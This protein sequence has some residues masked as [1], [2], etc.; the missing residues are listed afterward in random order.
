MAIVSDQAD[1]QQ[2]RPLHT[3][4]LAVDEDHV[5]V[6]DLNVDELAGRELQPM[7]DVR[8]LFFERQVVPDGSQVLRESRT[9]S[10]DECALPPP[11]QTAATCNWFVSK[12]P[13]AVPPLW[14]R[15]SAAVGGAYA[16]THSEQVGVR[17]TLTGE[18]DITE[19]GTALHLCIA[20]AGVLGKADLPEVERILTNWK[21][22]HAVDKASVLAPLTAFQDW[23]QQRW[24]G[25]VIHV[26][27]P[28]ET[29]R[30]D[31]TRLRGRIDL[32]VD[33]PDGWVLLDHKSN[34]RG[35]AADGQLAQDHGPQLS[36]Y[37]EA[38]KRATGRPVIEQWLYLPVAA[39]AIRLSAIS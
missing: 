2:F 4:E 25:C 17:V 37:A 38:L 7:L 10:P 18:V 33:T 5:Y 29:G 21:V 30:P 26:E 32:L 20:R 35:A 8:I 22:V 15:P 3:R 19:L 1:G 14:Y 34:P 13:K 23:L 9:W 11:A 39:R 28:V 27:V 36:A 24:A 12:P 31:G 6:A 16:V